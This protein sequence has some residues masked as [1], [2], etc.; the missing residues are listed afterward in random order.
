[1]EKKTQ[2]DNIQQQKAQHSKAQQNTPQ[3]ETLTGIRI[4]KYLSSAGLCSRREADRLVEEG[5]I[6]IDGVTASAGDR[7]LP[8]Q[9][10]TA[11]GREVGGQAGPEPVIY[12]VNKPAGVICSS[13]HQ[14]DTPILSDIITLPERVFYVG[15]LDKD[16]EG[17]LLLTNQGDL[18]DAMM[19]ARNYHEKE[20]DVTVDRPVTE[21][22]L[23][24]MAAG[25]F[26]EELGAATRPCRVSRT[27]GNRFRIILT[28]GL[29]RQI[30]RMCAAF[31]YEVKALKRV[32]IM[33]LTLGSLKPGQV[34]ALTKEE[35]DMLRSEAF[36]PR[37]E[38]AFSR[39]TPG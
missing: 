4:N 28:Q 7:V 23:H 27:G 39:G 38:A 26:L 37:D 13:V 12:M 1:M 29:N 30:R 9:K 19:R 3:D 33:H 22:F 15:R 17:L 35:A 11:D 14:S 36:S 20:Y 5:R 24:G 32:R 34:R 16:S 2:Q 8:G 18:A 31:G 10:V 21:A 6:R 25:V